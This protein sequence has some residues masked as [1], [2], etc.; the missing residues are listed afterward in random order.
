MGADGN[1]DC[2]NSILRRKSG[3]SVAKCIS[4][5]AYMMSQVKLLPVPA[6]RFQV[7]A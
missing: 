5:P 3:A 1:A 2:F 6:D 4:F 7:E